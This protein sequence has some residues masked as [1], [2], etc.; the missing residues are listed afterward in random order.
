MQQHSRLATVRRLPMRLIAA[1]AGRFRRLW[2][3]RPVRIVGKT[4]AVGFILVV[5][6]VAGVNACIVF[7]T[8]GHRFDTLDELPAAPAAE[9]GA[10]YQAVIVLGAR[11]WR[12]GSPS[13]ILRDRLVTGLDV[14]RSGR[15]GKI[16]VSGDHGRQS[17]DEVNA[18]RLWLMEAGVPAEDIFMDHAGFNTYDSMLRA[19]R[20]FGVRRAVVIT[21]DFHL[22]RAVW[23]AQQAGIE[24]I[25]LKA[26][27][28][29]YRKEH[30]NNFRESL[31]RVK[32]AVDV[33]SGRDPKYLGPAIAI[34]GDGRQTWD[35]VAQTSPQ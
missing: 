33:A 18:M 24:A 15:A 27:R 6:L 17:Y 26:D 19:S 11:V 35:N 32:A 2:S 10:P 25:G 5:L 14:Y 23:L 31:A 29:R 34:E 22:P 21:Q 1:I 28:H 12:D 8:S 3:L 20:I 16:I 13:D 30:W 4:A 9:S 7:G